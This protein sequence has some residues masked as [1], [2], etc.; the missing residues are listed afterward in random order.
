MKNRLTP[1]LVGCISAVGDPARALGDRVQQR[2][3]RRQPDERFLP[4]S[5]AE[6]RHQLQRLPAGRLCRLGERY[7]VLYLLHGRGDSMSAWTQMK[8]TLDELIA[9]E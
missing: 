9:A 5:D 6:G 1:V 4:F 3:P 2:R 8:S 7:P